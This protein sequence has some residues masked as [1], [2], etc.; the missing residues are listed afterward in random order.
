MSAR[1]SSIAEDKVLVSARMSAREDKDALGSARVEGKPPLSTRST[2]DSARSSVP[3]SSR[4]SSRSSTATSR[5][6]TARTYMDTSRVHVA[7]AA[8]GAEKQSLLMKLQQIDSALEVGA[9]KKAAQSR[10][11]K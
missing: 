6:D 11:R 2:I 4:S 5:T 1:L 8:L 3:E 7:L 9:R 10:P